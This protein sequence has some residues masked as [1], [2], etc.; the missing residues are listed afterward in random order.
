[1]LAEGATREGK[2]R[3]SHQLVAVGE[4][5][6][7]RDSNMQKIKTSELLCRKFLNKIKLLNLC[8]SSKD[9]DEGGGGPQNSTPKS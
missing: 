4:H 1:M 6:V 9:S 7:Q 8:I 2:M 3:I 5:C